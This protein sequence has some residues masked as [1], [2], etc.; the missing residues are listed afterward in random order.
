MNM[1]DTEEVVQKM[2]SH[3]KWILPTNWKQG[4]DDFGIRR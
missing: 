4:K 1:Q 2:Y 3:I